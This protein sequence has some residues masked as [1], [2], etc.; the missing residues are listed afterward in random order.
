[1]Q[2]T[3]SSVT[4]RRTSYEGGAL[5][6]LRKEDG[7]ILAVECISGFFYHGDAQFLH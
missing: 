1:M 5:R 7:L 4:L 6:L 3:P 2:W